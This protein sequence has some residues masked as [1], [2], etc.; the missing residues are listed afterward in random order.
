[1]QGGL[2]GGRFE[3]KDVSNV[4]VLLIFPP[5]ILPNPIQIWYAGGFGERPHKK[6][7]SRFFLIVFFPS[8]NLAQ[9]FPILVCKGAWREATLKL[10]MRVSPPPPLRSGM[11]AFVL[12]VALKFGVRVSFS[13]HQIKDFKSRICV[14]LSSCTDVRM[15][16]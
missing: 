6:D 14:Y 2:A 9:A 1:M 4:F 10:R 16:M 13:D 11:R 7:V 12:L 3:I 5:L 8:L 15:H